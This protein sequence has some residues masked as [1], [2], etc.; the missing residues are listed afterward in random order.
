[1]QDWDLRITLESTYSTHANRRGSDD[2]KLLLKDVCWDIP[3]TA[4]TMT[5]SEYVLY[6]WD[7][8]AGTASGISDVITIST[9]M[10]ISWP[11]PDYC[12]GY[13]YS[14]TYVSGPSNAPKYKELDVDGR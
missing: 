8:N 10:D 11:D 1:M 5:Q 7:T 2:F 3:L 13:S 4:P 12:G 14:I 9:P 6:L